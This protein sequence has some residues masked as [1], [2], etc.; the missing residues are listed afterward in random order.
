MNNYNPKASRTIF[1][2]IRTGIGGLFALRT[3]KMLISASH[4]INQRPWL[5]YPRIFVGQSYLG[6]KDVV[7]VLEGGNV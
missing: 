7:S 5:E 1:T 6:M 4:Y 2:P 3:E